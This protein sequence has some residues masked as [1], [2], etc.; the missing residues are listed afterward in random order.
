M[1]TLLLVDT[2]FCT[3]VSTASVLLKDASAEAVMP[4]KDPDAPRCPEMESLEPS[5]SLRECLPELPF[6]W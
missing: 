5:L 2:V 4:T 3:M 6:L 1:A